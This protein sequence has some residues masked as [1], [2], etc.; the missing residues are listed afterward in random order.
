MTVNDLYKSTLPLIFENQN[1]IEYDSYLFPYLNLL[2]Q[3]NFD[4]NNSIRLFKDLEKLTTAQRIS[5]KND[6]LTYEIEMTAE[7]LL[8]GLAALL[9]KEDDMLTTNGKIYN[10]YMN[11]Y[12][13]A[14]NRVKKAI[15]EEIED[16]YS[17][18][19]EDI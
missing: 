11:L 3:Q 12:I 14:Q 10:D 8:Y 4:I 16:V 1:S 19:E 6:I 7:V 13:S 5:S 15:P 18:S 9:I 17:V 2:L